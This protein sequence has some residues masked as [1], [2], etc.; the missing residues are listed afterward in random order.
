MGW[1]GEVG[2]MGRW[3]G[4]VGFVF[5]VTTDSLLMAPCSHTLTP[6]P[7]ISTKSQTDRGIDTFLVCLA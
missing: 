7:P 5:L 4:W 2:G 3:V 1:D 6:P